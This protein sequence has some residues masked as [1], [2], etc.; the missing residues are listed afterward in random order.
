MV[1]TLTNKTSGIILIDYWIHRKAISTLK[2]GR[3]LCVSLLLSFN[4][5]TLSTT[6]DDYIILYLIYISLMWTI[7]LRIFYKRTAAARRSGCIQNNYQTL[8]LIKCATTHIFIHTYIHTH[9]YI[10][11]YTYNIETHNS[12]SLF[13]PLNYPL[14]IVYSDIAPP[15]TRTGNPLAIGIVVRNTLNECII[16]LVVT[17]ACMWYIISLKTLCIVP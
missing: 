13:S 3:G 11:I 16:S 1:P 2:P 8:I 15:T 10:Y 5:D 4:Y 6:T 17:C 14:P 9:I 12:G 7:V